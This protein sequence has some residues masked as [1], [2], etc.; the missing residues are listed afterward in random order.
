[1]AHHRVAHPVDVEGCFGCR[2]LGIGYQGLQSR[3]GA[4]PVQSV[5]VRAD[6]GPA[7]GTTVGTHRVHWD[8]R[9]DAVVKAP[10]TAL[11]ATSQEYR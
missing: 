11:K 7:A 6:T 9:Q 2:C 3:Q 8:G 10:T 1:M 4:D 5:P